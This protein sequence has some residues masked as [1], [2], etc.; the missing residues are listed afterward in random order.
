MNFSFFKRTC[1]CLQ[2]DMKFERS[3][4]EPETTALSLRIVV[5]FFSCTAKIKY[6]GNRF[7]EHKSEHTI[8][9][10]YNPSLLLRKPSSKLNP[11]QSVR[12]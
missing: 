2:S 9:A 7:T 11:V 4:I 5:F 10:G 1:I 8:E 6:F 12:F 3:A